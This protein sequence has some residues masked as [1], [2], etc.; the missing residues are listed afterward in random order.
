M[1]EDLR[2]KYLQGLPRNLTVTQKF[3]LLVNRLKTEFPPEHPV[4]VRRCKRDLMG[5]DA[6]FGTCHLANQSKVKNQR[7]FVIT[8]RMTDPWNI[9]CDT[10]IHEWAHSLTWYELPNGKDHG[11]LFARKQGV[12]YREYIED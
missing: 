9:Q 10:L 7:Y 1:T 8:I 4:R 11:D 3:R 2:A 5:P 6:P 12:L